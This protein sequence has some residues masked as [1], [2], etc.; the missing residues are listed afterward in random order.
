MID[1][2][3]RR[4]AYRRCRRGLLRI[5]GGLAGF[6]A[7]TLVTIGIVVEQPL[8]PLLGMFTAL[9]L[10]CCALLPVLVML[11]ERFGW[12]AF[13]P[14]AVYGADPDRRR[15]VATAV[16]T[17][18]HLVGEDEELALDLA[19]NQRAGRWGCVL[20]FPVAPVLYAAWTAWDGELSWIRVTGAALL[21]AG[22]AVVV[23]RES[24]GARRYL[25]APPGTAVTQK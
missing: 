22:S 8:L 3:L 5:F 24:D 6:L 14:A 18:R 11:G 15:R 2:E 17:G 12:R 7:V 23:W 19:R 4:R 16:E 10:P 25:D 13:R 21:G 20:P 1:P 9:V